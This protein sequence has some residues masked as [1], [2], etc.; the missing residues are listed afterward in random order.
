MRCH[1]LDRAIQV[2]AAAVCMPG[3]VLASAYA[4]ARTLRLADGP[5]EVPLGTIAKLEMSRY[6]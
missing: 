4:K 2:H 3:P 6:L 5:D 1:V